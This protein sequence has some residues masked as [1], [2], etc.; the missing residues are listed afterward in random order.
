M[1]WGPEN[2]VQRRWLALS[3]A[4]NL[5]CLQ[6]SHLLKKGVQLDDPKSLQISVWHYSTTFYDS[7]TQFTII[8]REFSLKILKQEFK[9]VKTVLH[10]YI[11]IET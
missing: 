6:F 11:Y 1:G 8:L 3:K 9:H 2:Q 7:I 4:L 10:N 5:S